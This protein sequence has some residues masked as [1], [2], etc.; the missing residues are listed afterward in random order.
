MRYLTYRLA[1]TFVAIFALCGC[2]TLE[3][4]PEST[5]FSVALQ[6]ASADVEPSHEVRPTNNVAATNTNTESSHEAP[7]DN[8][9]SGTQESSNKIHSADRVAASNTTV[10]S[11]YDTQP[12]DQRFGL[13]FHVFGL[14]YHP[15]RAGTRLNHLDNELNAGLGLGYQF[16]NDARGQAN[17]EGGFF[18]D[19]GNHLAKFAGAG[20]QFKLGDHLRFGADLLAIQSKTYN[21]GNG[22]VAP[23]PRLT[24]DFGTVKLNATYIPKVPQFNAFSV[25][26]IYLT[27][28]IKKW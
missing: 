4:R 10:E 12:A 9:A 27:I 25:F 6:T 28:P 5:L 7:A 15:D 8:V 24:Y 19:S 2:G 16:H 17:V 1:P 18:K 13:N 26:A 3:R 21:K 22:F 14:S 11:A 23:I 20:Y